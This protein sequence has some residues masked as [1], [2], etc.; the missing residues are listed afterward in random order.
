MAGAQ[1]L[2]SFLGKFNH[3][4]YSGFE[5]DLHVRCFAGQ[6]FINLQAG[7]GHVQPPPPDHAQQKEVSPSRHRRRHRREQERMKAG[8]DLAG[9]AVAEKAIDEQIIAEKAKAIADK[10]LADKAIAEQVIAEKHLVESNENETQQDENESEIVEPTKALEER[11]NNG[12][13]EE[14]SVANT[15]NYPVKETE[16]E[17]V[18]EIDLTVENEKSNS[19]EEIGERDIYLF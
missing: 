3:L 4:W 5:A 8:K 18:E 19:F 10:T 13:V 15:E 17:S 16:T 1:E 9:K 7:L 12:K 14:V 11:D 2:Q 6:A